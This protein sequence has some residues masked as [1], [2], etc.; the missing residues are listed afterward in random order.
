M[1]KKYI[2]KTIITKTQFKNFEFINNC[3][4][5]ELN[6]ETRLIIIV[7]LTQIIGKSYCM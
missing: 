7:L 1:Y 4:S 6:V 2:I 3:L 5:N